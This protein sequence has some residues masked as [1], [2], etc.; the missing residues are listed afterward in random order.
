VAAS[1]GVTANRRGREVP[2]VEIGADALVDLVLLRPPRRRDA[3]GARALRRRLA[4]VV[5]VVPPP[6]RGLAA[7]EEDVEAAAL[8]AVEVLH[9]ERLAR[10]RPRAELG[11]GE[12]EL[13]RRKDLRDETVLAE[14]L[15]EVG[16]GVRGRLVYDDRTAEVLQRLAVRAGREMGRTVAERGGRVAHP[17]Q[18]QVELLAVERA[19]RE[20]P[21]R[22]DEHHVTAC[23]LGAGRGAQLITEDPQRVVA[24]RTI[25]Q[26][27]LTFRL[28]RAAFSPR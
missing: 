23:V 7:V 8:V 26:V 14:A 9:P 16:R 11:P 4:V 10:A 20:H 28:V 12:G 22:L 27:R 3:Q 2:R 24:H 25:L 17:G 15:D 13:R 5:V 18:H 1:S 21:A 19:A 6:A